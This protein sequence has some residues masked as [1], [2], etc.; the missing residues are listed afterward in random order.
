M[1]YVIVNPWTTLGCTMM[2]NYAPLH[3]HTS[4]TRMTTKQYGCYTHTFY[5]M[6]QYKSCI[7][8]H[9]ES[10]VTQDTRHRF[11][12][13]RIYTYPSSPDLYCTISRTDS[14]DDITIN[15]MLFHQSAAQAMSKPVI[16]TQFTMNIIRLCFYI[17]CNKEI[18][19]VKECL[20]LLW[21]F[22]DFSVLLV[23]FWTQTLR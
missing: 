14:R 7:Q 16:V 8:R 4:T 1:L 3:A 22:T 17:T 19:F 10:S 9:F 12:L 18:V 23:A 15:T 13:P 5:N 20:T 11:H 6:V 21:V 2:K